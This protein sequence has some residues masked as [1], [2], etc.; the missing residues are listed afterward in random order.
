MFDFVNYTYSGILSIIAALIG[1]GCPLIIGRIEDIDKRYKS[2][3]L[4]SRFKGESSFIFFIV[5]MIVNIL[6]TIILPF[7]L[8]YSTN[9][10]LWIALQSIFV[11]L[12]LVSLFVLF[13]DILNYLDPQKLQ[14]R[15]L[16]DYDKNQQNGNKA[17]KYFNQWVDLTPMILN[18]ADD[19][20]AQTIYVEWS[21]YISNAY[22]RDNNTGELEEYLLKGLTRINENLCTGER[23]L[24]SINN[25]N[26]ILKSLLPYKR[27]IPDNN[28]RCL[29]NNLLLQSYYGRDEWI[30]EYWDTASQLYEYDKLSYEEDIDKEENIEEQRKKQEI[31]KWKFL[32]FHIMLVAILLRQKKYSLV[33]DMLM[34]S[35]SMPET[36][37]LV[38][39][40]ISEI[41]FAF[42]KINTIS[43][44]EAFYFESHYPI[45]NV[46][47]ISD[48]VIIGAAFSYLTLLIYRVYTLH[49]QYGKSA[50]L[51]HRISVNDKTTLLELSKWRDS[52]Q[53][54]QRWVERLSNEKEL[55]DVV[56][57]NEQT[58]ERLQNGNDSKVI[59]PPRQIIEDAELFIEKSMQKIKTE[60]PNDDEIE[61][62]MREKVVSLLSQALV[63]YKVLEDSSFSGEKKYLINCSISQ[64]YPNSAFQKGADIS[65]VNIEETLAMSALN[66]FTQSISAQYYLAKRIQTYII[67]YNDIVSA[68]GKLKP[69]GK[70]VILSF[71]F[72]WNNLIGVSNKLSRID[73]N[74][75]KYDNTYIY[76]LPCHHPMTGR[77]L[78]IVEE[79]ELHKLCYEK[80]NQN[81]ID[82][83]QLTEQD[84]KYGIWLSILQLSKNEKLKEHY[85]ALGDKI[86][87]YSLF[88]VGWQPRIIKNNA[89]KTIAI[90]VWYEYIEE[91]KPDDVK[92]VL[93]IK[94]LISKDN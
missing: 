37:P 39:S 17:K 82:N 86:D 73:D 47:G 91:G 7:V 46:H 2:T 26:W 30:L 44:V 43:D 25:G 5:M 81:Q 60:R 94:K 33:K 63:P 24:I 68:L 75:C 8:D 69:N 32:E 55:L 9:A 87:E 80:P 45:P 15:I 19:Q 64:S 48:G 90:R 92:S 29:W 79:K 67:S 31:E 62:V 83:Y 56:F 59:P 23:R 89:M 12:L 3:L 14:K 36:Y 42:N 52:L 54:I 49:W 71:G 34:L 21:K 11:L 93:S 10:R 78:Y 22:Q 4:T 57:Y 51:D 77:M 35:N 84:E 18:S 65:Y 74:T 1:L 66:E 38:P 13:Y 72:T 50:A 70:H 28:Y 85:K 6:I 88:T 53:I 61:K 27:T 16:D 41:L 40:T 58:I 76:E 20:V